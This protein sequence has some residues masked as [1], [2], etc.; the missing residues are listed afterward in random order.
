MMRAILL[1]IVTSISYPSF[2]QNSFKGQISNANQEPIVGAS[3]VEVSSYLGSISNAEGEFHLKNL[4]NGLHVFKIQFIGFKTITDSITFNGDFTKNYTLEVNPF[5]ADEFVVEATR[6]GKSTPVTRQEFTK[7]QIEANNLG[8]DLPILLNQAVSTVTTSDAGGGVGYT[9]MRIRGSD[10]TRINVTV[11]GV[12][13][14]DAESHGVF[15]VNMPDFSSNTSKIQIQRGVGTSSNGA[16]AF[17]ASVNLQTTGI[18]STTFVE[19]NN[20]YGSFNTRK[21]NVIYNSGLV[22][23]H[24]NFEGRLSYIGSDGYIDRSSS[25]LRSYYLSGGY[26]RK[27]MMIK[28]VTFSGHEV[29]H[30]AWYGTPESRLSGSIDDMTIHALNNGYDEKQTQNLLNSGRTYNYYQYKNEVDDYQQTHYQLITGFQLSRK[31]YL[32]ITGHYTQ[33]LGFF[34]QSKPNENFSALG[35][36][37]PIIGNDTVSKSDVILRRWLNN[38]FYGGVYS[39]QYT[40]RNLSVTLGGSMNEYTGKHYGEI[41][42]AEFAQNTVVDQR[43]YFSDAH[44][45]DISNYLRAEY[46]IKKITFYADAQFRHIAYESQGIDN[47][48]RQ[49]KIN[50]HYN[51]FNPK[52][53]INWRINSGNNLYV[54]AAQSSREPVRSDFTDAISGAVP[55]PEFMT[56][57]ELGW[58][59]GAKFWQF[60]VN[61]YFMNYKNQLVQTGELNDVGSPIRTNVPESYRAG[62]ELLGQINLSNGLYWQPNLT[63]SQ[64]KI[65]T[66]NEVLYDYTSGYDVLLIEHK[67]AD[68]AFSPSIISGSE[69][70]YK[71]KVGLSLTLLTKFVGRQ[72]LDNTSNAKRSIDPYITNDIRIAYQVVNPNWKRLEFTLLF[73]NI[74]NELY[75]SN[76]YTYSY[77]FG[78]TITEN[79]YYPQAGRNW[80]FGIK[81]C[82]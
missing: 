5:V 46:Q 34:E 36:Q 67:N 70:G 52:A 63:V 81:C 31:L 32:N 74:L 42:W 27:K 10:G 40:K 82:F 11:N 22:S 49:I 60:G 1:V 24:F 17:G 29:T 61:A 30:Q 71:T 23:K 2:S 54:S 80:L 8:Q 69:L 65:A 50:Q 41:H 21:H 48:Q 38:H 59:H 79:F 58:Q 62:L 3:I 77:V 13:I 25:D 9:G 53:G 12:P 28:A 19:F 55:K 66:F 6:A 18:D 45:L 20:S 16:A 75:S 7:E 15:W 33:G 47:D 44:K 14:N 35:L 73:N 26:Y 76:G 68:I 57:A 43:Y 37:D 56:N 78:S 51:F 72:F 64:N 4:S 39:L